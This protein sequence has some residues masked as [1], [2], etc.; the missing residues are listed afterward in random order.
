MHVANHIEP[1]RWH[2]PGV[3]AE[4]RTVEAAV[5]DKFC[6]ALDAYP[7]SIDLIYEAKQIVLADGV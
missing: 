7:Q 5:T 2:P 6:V 3:R 4:T 1:G